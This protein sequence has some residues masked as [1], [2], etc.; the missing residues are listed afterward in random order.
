M[1]V[2]ET[3]ADWY[4]RSVPDILFLYEV[5]FSGRYSW[6]NMSAKHWIG[7]AKAAGQITSEIQKDIAVRFDRWERRYN[8]VQAQY[9]GK[10][11]SAP[12][13]RQRRLRDE[14][15]EVLFED[16]YGHNPAPNMLSSG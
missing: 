15:P 11:A 4:R 16:V 5:L 12:S 13:N 10:L 14:I 9:S 7:A 8:D 3:L 2:P 6:L 1:R